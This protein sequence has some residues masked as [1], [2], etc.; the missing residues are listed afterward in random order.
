MSNR[1]KSTICLFITA[2]IWGSAFVAQRMGMDSIGP[3]YFSAFR[4]LLGTVALTAVFLISDYKNKLTKHTDEEKKKERKVLWVG[5]IACGIIIF[6]ASNLQQVGLVSVDAG[7]T[8]F[9]T[10]LYI[11][12]VPIF[13]IF[14]KHKTNIFN[15]I[16][17]VIGVIGLYFLCITSEF[18]ILPGDLIVLIGAFFWAFHILCLDYFAP[19]TNVIKLTAIQFLVA[20][21][22]S[23]GVAI[24]REPISFDAVSGAAMAITYTGIF[25]TAIAFSFQALGQK[26]ANPTTASIILSTESLFALIFGVIILGEVM[27]TKEIIGCILMFI[28]IIIAQIPSKKDRQINE[29]SVGISIDTQEENHISSGEHNQ[30]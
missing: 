7:K 9:I 19:K 11:I 16:G 2:I 17:A 28:A 29:A 23:L 13:G 3:F 14:L 21:L 10:A 6:F 26:N 1:I 15:W 4:M 5:G 8:G 27:T 24:L 30:S 12:L 25:S 18:S 22:I 20:G